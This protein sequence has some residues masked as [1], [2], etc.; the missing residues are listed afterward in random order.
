MIRR[1]K[2]NYKAT[3]TIP[4]IFARRVC[5]HSPFFCLGEIKM[6]PFIWLKSCIFFMQLYVELT[7]DEKQEKNIPKDVHLQIRHLSASY[8]R[9][10]DNSI[11]DYRQPLGSYRKIEF[12]RFAT[13]DQ[14]KCEES[15]A[16]EYSGFEGRIQIIFASSSETLEWP[17]CGASSSN[18]T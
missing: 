16:R 10:G 12:N 14:K 8:F 2:V 15:T 13:T 5:T 7:G 4:E 3:H 11:K 6:F 17:T 9:A 1:T 18:I